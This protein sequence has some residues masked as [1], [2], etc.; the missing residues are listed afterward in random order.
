LIQRSVTAIVFYSLK[1]PS[2]KYRFK[3]KGASLFAVA[4]DSPIIGLSQTVPGIKATIASLIVSYHFKE[5]SPEMLTF[6]HF[7]AMFLW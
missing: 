6:Q 3:G 5:K 1:C 2:C 4:G 7:R